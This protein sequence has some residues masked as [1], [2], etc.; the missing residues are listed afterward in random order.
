MTRAEDVLQM[1]AAVFWHLMGTWS[2]TVC[3]Q[4]VV[5][6]YCTTQLSSGGVFFLMKVGTHLMILA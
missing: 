3:V 2:F 6:V 5:R 4:C 1:T